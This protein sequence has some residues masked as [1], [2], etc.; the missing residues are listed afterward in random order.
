MILTVDLGNS[1]I[2]FGVFENDVLKKSMRIKTDKNRSSDEYH[3]SMISLFNTKNIPINEIEGVI[4]SSVVPSLTLV[5]SEAVFQITH[6]YPIIVGPGVKTG[7]PIRT[8][9]AN[10]VGADLICGSVGAKEKFGYPVII[11]DFGTATKIN[12]I[13]KNGAFCGCVIAPGLKV[14]TEALVNMAS[15]L[16]QVNYVA[17]KKIVGK[18]TPDSMNSGSV[19]G[20]AFMID[21]FIENIEKELGYKFR[22]VATGGLSK[23]VIPFCNKNIE[24]CDELVLFGLY[25]IYL[26]NH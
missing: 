21:G 6:S 12:V 17:P 8:D 26:K 16:P 24:I 18:N 1:N 7:L 25:Q 20:H 13:D 3:M 10:E 4:I 11:V 15:Q 14:A 22:I 5:L 2:V 9:N 19:Y 23:L